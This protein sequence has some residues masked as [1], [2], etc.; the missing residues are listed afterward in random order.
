ML[1]NTATLTQDDKGNPTLLKGKRVTRVEL[2]D[3]WSLSEAFTSITQPGR[4]VWD[5]Q[6][7]KPPAWVESDNEELET[8]LADHYGCLVGKR[9]GFAEE[10][11]EGP[12]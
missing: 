4:G 9:S 8:L 2:P 7:T 11:W 5:S 12:E 3:E 1:G 10:T 6:S